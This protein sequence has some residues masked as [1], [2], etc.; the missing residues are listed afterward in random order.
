[1]QTA[2]EQAGGPSGKDASLPVHYA[3]TYFDGQRAQATAC[4]LYA[5]EASLGVVN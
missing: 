3:P 2:T 4:A 5:T 1:M